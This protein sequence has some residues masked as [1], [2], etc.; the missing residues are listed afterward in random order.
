[1]FIVDANYGIKFDRDF[2]ITE[3]VVEIVKKN[4]F[5]N[6]FVLN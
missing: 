6:T 4:K 3:K 2:E 5:P 1:M